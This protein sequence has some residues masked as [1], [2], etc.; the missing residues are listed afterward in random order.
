MQIF[1]LRMIEIRRLLTAFQTENTNARF[2]ALFPH[3]FVPSLNRIVHNK[4]KEKIVYKMNGIKNVC[5]LLHL[6]IPF[7]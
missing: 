5:F 4:M 6:R 2:S 1:R 3:Q 7:L